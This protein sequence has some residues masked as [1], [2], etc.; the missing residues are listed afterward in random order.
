LQSGKSFAQ[1]AERERERE[2]ERERERYEGRKEGG[3]ETIFKATLTTII[4]RFLNSK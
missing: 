1:K 3:R 4:W 2:T